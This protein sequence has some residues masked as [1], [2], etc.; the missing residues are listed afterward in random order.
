M[1]RSSFSKRRGFHV[2]SSRLFHSSHRRRRRANALHGFTLIELLVVIAIISLLVSILLPSLQKAKELA[3]ST[4]CLS[5]VR[6]IGLAMTLFLEENDQTFPQS[7]VGSGSTQGSY[8]WKGRL[9]EYLGLQLGSSTLAIANIAD[10]P[11]ACPSLEATDSSTVN[12]SMRVAYMPHAGSNFGV[13]GPTAGRRVD[14][15]KKRLDGLWIMGEIEVY[16]GANDGYVYYGNYALGRDLI[17]RRHEGRSNF[18]FGDMHVE[19][20]EVDTLHNQGWIH[21][22]RVR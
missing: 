18:L 5:N 6:S 4:L 12:K 15:I 16:M 7:G 14:D 11:F 13:I 9:A 2:R 22:F 3:R 8:M 21:N 19:P 20:I 1:K 10:S 17:S